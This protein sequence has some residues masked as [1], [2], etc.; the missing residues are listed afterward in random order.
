[1]QKAGDTKIVFCI[2]ERINLFDVLDKIYSIALDETFRLTKNDKLDYNKEEKY[3][4][5]FINYYKLGIE[6]LCEVAK[7]IT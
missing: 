2:F 3:L 1:M 5:I 6:G 4:K 7:N